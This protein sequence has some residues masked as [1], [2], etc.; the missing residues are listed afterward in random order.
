MGYL[1]GALGE[2]YINGVGGVEGP[3]HRGEFK[4]DPTSDLFTDFNY[5]SSEGV[6]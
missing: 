6:V 3:T 2:K 5:R 4:N 1:S